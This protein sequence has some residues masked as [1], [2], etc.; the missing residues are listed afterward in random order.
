MLCGRI[1][2]ETP[3]ALLEEFKLYCKDQH[4]ESH[5]IDGSRT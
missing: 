5:R 1:T 3:R 2:I 4:T